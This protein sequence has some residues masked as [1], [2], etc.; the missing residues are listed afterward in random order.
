M[1][2]QNLLHLN[3]DKLF[4]EHTISEIQEINRKLQ[5]EIERKREELR[6]MVGERYRDLIE[7]ADTISDMKTTAEDVISHIDKMS[8]KCHKL[9]QRHLLGFKLDSRNVKTE[10]LSQNRTYHSIAV[11]IKI[12]MTLPEQIWSAVENEDYL[13]GTQLFLLAR[14][15]N[16][17]LQL[18]DGITANQVGTWFPV[19]A[20]QWSAISHFRWA[21][22]TGCEKKLKCHELT[23]EEAANCLCSLVLLEGLSSSNL[24]DKFLALRS[25]ALQLTLESDEHTSVKARVSTS[26]QLLVLTICLLYSCFLDGYPDGALQE[27]RVWRELKAIVG[28][29]AQPTA[30]HVELTDTVSLKY[31]PSLSKDFRPSTREP[32]EPVAPSAMRESLAKWLDWVRDYTFEKVSS[33][34]QLVSSVRGLQAVRAEANSVQVPDTWDSMCQRLLIPRGL[35]L[36]ETYFQTLLTSRAK[37]LVS[38]QWSTALQKLKQTLTEVADNVSSETC[39]QPENDLRWFVWKERNSDLPRGEK[40]ES[41]KSRQLRGLLMKARGYSPCVER[42][43]SELDSQLEAILHDLKFYMGD[44]V[45]DRDELLQHIQSVSQ[46][47]ILELISFIQSLCKEKQQQ[48][49]ACIILM[50]RFLQALCDLCPSLQHCLAKTNQNQILLSTEES[51][52]KEVCALLK[53]ESLS[54]WQMWRV[55]VSSRLQTIV[56]EIIVSPSS[57][58]ELLLSIPQWDVVSIEEEGEEGRKIQSDIKVPSQPSL[59]LQNL[60]NRACQELNAIAPHT[61]PRKIHQELV[62]QLVSDIFSAYSLMSESEVVGQAQALQCL[63][64]V[65][66]ITMLLV[67]RDNKKLVG[68]CTELCDKFEDKVDPF[69]LDVFC[70]YIQNNIKKSVHRTQ[71]LV[72]VLM[73]WPEKLSAMSGM[74]APTT[75][76]TKMEAPSVLPLCEGV[77]WFTSLPV[78][79]LPGTRTVQHHVDKP[80]LFGI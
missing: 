48:S 68:K 10:R 3:P 43:C 79:G 13:L 45:P 4:E 24:L 58:A 2:V 53:Q 62:E 5:A 33:L 76:T 19:V 9:Q 34:L 80:Q 60:L 42:L 31:L 73:A 70:P 52:W 63:L 25:Q 39:T 56:N 30:S 27:G 47:S 46:S 1:P 23:S 6:T 28:R 55:L 26:L 8:D 16:T 66:Y 74:R 38:Q 29:E 51:L 69:D 40:E 14:H 78:T 22:P 75:S 32:V 59:P 36:W 72:G 49:E 37:E 61:L 11:Q 41:S 67:P 65:K 7:A 18:Q 44:N 21:I 15:I 35:N 77:P 12:L 57:I 54:T 71:S 50:A 20:R 17:G 64:D